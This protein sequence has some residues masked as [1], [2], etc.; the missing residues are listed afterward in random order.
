MPH[1]CWKYLVCSEGYFSSCLWAYSRIV[2]TT[3]WIQGAK[4]VLMPKPC[5][6][7]TWSLKYARKG[8]CACDVN[9]CIQYIYVNKDIDM[10]MGIDYLHDKL[11]F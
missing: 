4:E 9:R 11:D 5:S 10:S 1:G 6:W 8:E 3:Y 2:S 7:V